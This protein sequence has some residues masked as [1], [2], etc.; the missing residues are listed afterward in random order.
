[1]FCQHIVGISGNHDA[2]LCLSKYVVEMDSYGSFARLLPTTMLC[3]WLFRCC[4][5]GVYYVLWLQSGEGDEGEEGDDE[6][7]DDE[8][9]NEEEPYQV[10]T[11][12]VHLK[13]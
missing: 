12:Y 4:N 3:L 13:F 6:E 2:M 1:M 9:E 11:W 8:Q 7:D 5:P 10:S